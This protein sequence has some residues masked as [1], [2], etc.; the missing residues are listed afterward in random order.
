VAR[1]SVAEAAASPR[2]RTRAQYPLSGDVVTLECNVALRRATDRRSYPALLTVR[3][4]AT[5][6]DQASYPVAGESPRFAELRA[7][8]GDLVAG[9]GVLA[10]AAASSNGW[11]FLLYVDAGS[12]DWA[13]GFEAE[14]RSA[15][16]DHLVGF[17][18]TRDAKWTTFARLSPRGSNPVVGVITLF[19]ILPLIGTLPA[20]SYHPHVAWAFGGAASM[21]VWLLPLAVFRKKLLAA[22]LA[23]PAMAF[24]A[25]TYLL[26]AL[27][28][29]VVV[30]LSHG[31]KVAITIGISVGLSVVLVGAF[32]PAQQRYY[33]R[34]R[35][36]ARLAQPSD[37]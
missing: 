13:G 26:A 24:A 29:P 2:W 33:A 3:V 36:R 34:M 10:A 8:I 20:T 32:W 22:Q 12:A 17:N 15:L 19:V 18:V 37:H 28:F 30:T 16:S 11:I 21:L 31:A 1:V 7:R 4:Q 23:R 5:A 9:H 27:F 25:F 6:H 14:I 35:D